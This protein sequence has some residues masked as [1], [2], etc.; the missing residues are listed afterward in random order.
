[1]LH[2]IWSIHPGSALETAAVKRSLFLAYGITCYIISF[3]S[4]LYLVGFMGNW[5]VPKS[6]DQGPA[7]GALRATIVDSALIL[8]FALQHL[9]MARQEFKSRWT[10]IVPEPIERSTFV[11]AAS[12]CLILLFVFWTPIPMMVWQADT[13]ALK[14]MFEAAYV[15]GWLI[16]LYSSFVIDHF[17]LFGLR[18][19]YLYFRGEPYTPV[20]FQVS[21]FYKYTRHPMMLGFL[22]VFWCTP[23]MTLGHVVLAAGFT[24]FIFLGI[25][26]EEREML[27][28]FGPNYRDYRQKTSMLVPYV[29]KRLFLTHSQSGE[30]GETRKHGGCAGD[31]CRLE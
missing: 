18:Q 8:L 15:A 23:L 13:P 20:P 12:A 11:L 1:M 14:G 4:L 17:D 16:V 31:S 25:T 26:I 24:A 30:K 29:R 27:G 9:V 10:Q 7:T 22:L 3:G 5:V 2:S 28:S 19:V 21:S 6:V